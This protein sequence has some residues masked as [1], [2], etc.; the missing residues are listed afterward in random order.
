MAREKGEAMRRSPMGAIRRLIGIRLAAAAVLAVCFS[1]G[2]DG[3]GPASRSASAAPV[4]GAAANG[5]YLALECGRG[6]SNPHGVSTNR[7]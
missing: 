4:A 5:T 3:N 1:A 2:C 6:D 7:T